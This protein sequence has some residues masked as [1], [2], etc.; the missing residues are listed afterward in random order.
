MHEW[1]LRADGPPAGWPA[2]V[3]LAGVSE[4]EPGAQPVTVVV[5]GYNVV[6]SVPDGWWRDRP[7]AVRRLLERLVCYRHRAGDRV[8]LVLDVR[9]ADLSEGLYEGV[10]IRYAVRSGADA[11]DH[12]ILTL[13]G[14]RAG[15]RLR[16]VTSDRALA[17]GA[18]DR[19]ATVEGA[20]TL[21]R[22]LDDLGC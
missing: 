19:G 4:P 9:Q 21:L 12:E 6:G 17:A 22:R 15:D 5:D 7:A 20:N 10:E 1:E 11:A 8:V 3:R 2:R 18:V 13:L 16:V 14:E